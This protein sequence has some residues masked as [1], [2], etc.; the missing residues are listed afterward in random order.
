MKNFHLDLT[1]GLN[2]RHR[3]QGGRRKY[4]AKFA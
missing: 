2:I 1:S 4:C 3:G